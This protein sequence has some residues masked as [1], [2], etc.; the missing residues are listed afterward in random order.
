MQRTRIIIILL[1]FTLVSGLGNAIECQGASSGKKTVKKSGKCWKRVTWVDRTTSMGDGTRA[2]VY[3][4]SDL[5]VCMDFEKVLNTTCE[6]PKKLKCNWTLPPEE[7]KFQKLKWLPLNTKEYWPLIKDIRVSGVR[8]DQREI[9]WAQD[10]AR[11]EK[12]FEEG[13]R[14]LSTTWVDLDGD[15]HA[16]LVVRDDD[17]PCQKDS[18]ASFDVMN[19]KTVRLDWNYSQLVFDVNA[20]NEGGEIMLYNGKAYMFKYERYDGDTVYIYEGYP[21]SSLNICQFRYQRGGKKK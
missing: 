7:K 21:N 6:Q 16:E 5:P 9:V 12:L 11:T 3:V 18:G 1:I 8:E 2:P 10:G 20:S 14:A 17:I 19:P 4:R 15:K 13:K